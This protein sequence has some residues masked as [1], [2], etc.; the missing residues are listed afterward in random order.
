MNN[1][2][3]GVS[4]IYW[5]CVEVTGTDVGEQVYLSVT[6]ALSTMSTVFVQSGG[7]VTI[8]CFYE[9]RYKTRVKYWCKGSDWSS[10]TAIV[11]TNQLKISAEVSIRDDPDQRLFTVIM[12]NLKIVDSGYYW[13]GVDISRGS[14]VGTRVYLSVTEGVSTLN[15][16]TVERGGSVTIPCFY[17]NKYRQ[18]VKYWCRGS[19]WSSCTP[20]VRTDSP[21]TSDEV[22]IRDDPDQRVFNVTMNKQTTVN[23]GY[24]W[25]GVEI[26]RGSA[27]GTRVY[28]SVTEG[29]STMNT[30]TVERGGSVTIP[31][32]YDNKYRQYVKYWCRGSDWSSCTP[33][34][35]TDSPNISDEV[36][37]RDD[38]DQRVF[39]VTMNN[40]TT[41]NSGYYWCG[42]EISRGSAVGTQ[43]YLSVTEGVSTMNTVT[44]E[45]GGSVT[46]PC[47]YDNKYR[48]YVKYWC[49]GSDWSSCTPIVRTD[50][51]NISDEVLI[52]DDPDQRVFNVTMN[53]LTTENSG[54]YWCGVEI[55]RG[56]AVGTQVYL[57]VTEGVSTMNTV[58]VERGGS[59][60]IPCFY[61]NKYRQYVKYWCRGSD[62]SSCTP[63][64]RTDS[65]NISDEVSIRD[66]PDQ[67]VF[68]VTMNNL[69]TGNSGYYWCG[70][71]I[72]RGSAVGTRVYLSVT[73][74]DD[75]GG[76]NEKQR[77]AAAA[78]TE[79]N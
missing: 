61:D 16:V 62:W 27:V 18:Y 44:V 45:R 37:I 21:N 25:C 41:E 68:N 7:S 67:R 13:C 66:D 12:N 42:V 31:C 40:L 76:N 65:P 78:S 74:D 4:D 69:T 47:F 32:F 19:D 53:N 75:K 15:T 22:S 60:T 46:I 1:L 26:S 29:V 9:D 33:I 17:D 72:S 14:A 51:P 23:S 6:E 54:Y 5:C 30:V 77:D 55:S 20:I 70:V 38:P 34:V 57:S 43:V 73:E 2:E 39:N 50:S 49:R 28:L 10:C 24:Y 79:K 63:I 3:T 35:R 8:P 56:S 64:V 48:Q 52:R 59:V 71:E 11:R 58:T 36:S